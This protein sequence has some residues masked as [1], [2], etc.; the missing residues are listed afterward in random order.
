[1]LNTYIT[2]NFLGPSCLNNI[3]FFRRTIPVMEVS[4]VFKVT[5]NILA[6]LS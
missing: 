6:L 4:S 2:Q 3:M 1:M 5:E